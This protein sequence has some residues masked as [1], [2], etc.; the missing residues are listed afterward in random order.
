[1]RKHNIVP[2]LAIFQSL[3]NIC[4]LAGH[5]PRAMYFIKEMNKH[6]YKKND[7]LQAVYETAMK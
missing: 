1:L 4:M 6:K 3:Q 7:K 2:Q 5:M